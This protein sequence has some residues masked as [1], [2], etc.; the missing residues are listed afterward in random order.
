MSKT[1]TLRA[2]GDAVHRERHLEEEQERYEAKRVKAERY[3]DADAPS[4]FMVRSF[5][6]DINATTT[7]ILAQ[8]TRLQEQGKNEASDQHL[9]DACHI[10]NDCFVR[11]SRV[12]KAAKRKAE[13]VPLEEAFQ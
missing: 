6:T 9:A 10:L 8:L 12:E 7:G 13:F 1:I 3:G 5:I 2:M 11:L 4:P